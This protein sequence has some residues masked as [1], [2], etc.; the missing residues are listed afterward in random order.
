MHRRTNKRKSAY[1]VKRFVSGLAAENLVKNIYIKLGFKLLFQRWR[2]K[3]YEIDLIFEG[4][5]EF[6][7]PLL[8]FIEVR[9]TNEWNITRKKLNSLLK[10]MHIFCSLNQE[11]FIRHTKRLDIAIVKS[12]S[13]KLTVEIL[14]NCTF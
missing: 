7:F 8:V 3:R 12:L 4:V 9:K 13:N 11:K 6:G 1:Y 10:A 14:E 2:Y 5:D